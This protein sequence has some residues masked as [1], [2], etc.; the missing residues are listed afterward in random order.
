[1]KISDW[2]YN[3]LSR[4]VFNCCFS[5]KLSWLLTF[6]FFLCFFFVLFLTSLVPVCLFSC[7]SLTSAELQKVTLSPIERF[8][9]ESCSLCHGHN[10]KLYGSM[11]SLMSTEENW[12]RV[13]RH[14]IPHFLTHFVLFP[15]WSMKGKREYLC[16]YLTNS[17]EEL[18]RIS[19]CLHKPT[20]VCVTLSLF[21]SILP[22]FVCVWC[23]KNCMKCYWLS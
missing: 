10:N 12:H 20:R 18:S 17:L 2:G 6:S 1:M 4:S 5:A 11:T 7:L 19:V 22:A 16:I 23:R 13:L 8:Y 15:V 9:S 21:E 14:T 3:M